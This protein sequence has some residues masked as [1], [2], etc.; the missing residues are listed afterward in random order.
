MSATDRTDTPKAGAAGTERAPHAV[1]GAFGF[2]G[3]HIARQLLERGHGV[4]TLTGHPER[5]HGAEIAVFPLSF[6]APGELA[7]ALEGAEVLY[8]TYWVRF[9]AAGRTFAG[10]VE[11]S[12]RL[13]RAAREAGVG[14]IVHVSIT[15]ANPASPLPYFR[16]KGEVEAALAESS[17]P[18]SILRPALLFG[19][20]DVLVNNIAWM[21][22]RFPAFAI[23]G[24][25]DY[26]MRPI[27]VGELGALA[28]REGRHAE[29]QRAVEAVGPERLSYEALVRAVGDA[30]RRPGR[31][32]HV[33][34]PVVWC[35]G[36]LLGLAVGD[37]VLTRDEIRGLMAGLLD[38]DAPPAGDVRISRWLREN[39]EQIGLSWASELARHYR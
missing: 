20:G 34:P 32:V 4:R 15:H 11:N 6:D 37:V 24:R 1:T 36:R 14:R 22:R 38:S 26:A 23:P 27:H 19:A 35:I 30:I 21:L 16:G 9:E 29:A 28:V 17:V 33:S 25:G 3:R 13:F 18:H 5:A 10:A 2:T 7:R 12:R 31:M 39:A 8:N